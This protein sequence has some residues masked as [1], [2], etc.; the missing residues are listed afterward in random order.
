MRFLTLVAIL[1]IAFSTTSALK[2]Q[3]DRNRNSK[4]NQ[5]DCLKGATTV[6]ELMAK[7]GNCNEAETA[8][9]ARTLQRSG[10]LNSTSLAANQIN[11]IIARRLAE[12]KDSEDMKLAEVEEIMQPYYTSTITINPDGS[13][14]TSTTT[15]ML[16]CNEQTERY[17]EDFKL[18]C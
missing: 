18:R 17:S 14:I 15:T 10:L 13:K 1:L 8:K 2:L 6:K 7:V 16:P 3:N 4:S 9:L 11:S 12:S 5:P